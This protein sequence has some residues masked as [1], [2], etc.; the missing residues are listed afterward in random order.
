MRAARSLPDRL[1]PIL[2]HPELSF[3]DADFVREFDLR[4]PVVAGPAQ[5]L[6]FLPVEPDFTHILSL[7]FRAIIGTWEP[8]LYRHVSGSDRHF[9]RVP[10][11][12]FILAGGG[13]RDPMLR[14]A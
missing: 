2:D 9:R 14:A 5:R 11:K 13:L 12:A 10:M 3:A 4:C 8:A 6:H 1:V 7:Q